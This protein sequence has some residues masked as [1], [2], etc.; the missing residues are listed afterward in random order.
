MSRWDDY[1]KQRDEHRKI[2]QKL[3]SDDF[4]LV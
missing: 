3:Q 2:R 1:M 4:D